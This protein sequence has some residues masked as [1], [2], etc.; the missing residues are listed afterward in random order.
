M[1]CHYCGWKG[2]LGDLITHPPSEILCCPGANC[3]KPWV[4]KGVGI[5]P[6]IRKRARQQAARRAMEVYY[7]E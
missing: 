7:A 2:V 4:Q 3:G 6:V 5:I 1:E